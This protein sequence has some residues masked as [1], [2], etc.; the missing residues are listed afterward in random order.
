MSHPLP[1]A[2]AEAVDHHEHHSDVV[3]PDAI[4]F[5]MVHLAALGVFFT[6]F[7]RTSIILCI[8]FYFVRMWA[9]RAGISSNFSHP[10]R[11]QRR[12]PVWCHVSWPFLAQ[13]TAQKGALWCWPSTGTIHLH[14]IPRR[15]IPLPPASMGF[16][17]PFLPMLGVIFSPSKSKPDY[18][19]SRI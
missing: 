14:S 4:P 12:F 13:M 11:Y 8:T 16:L 5:A 18:P 1:T 7:T 6:G 2:H 10:S 3:Y 17:F 19:P 15:D 9:V